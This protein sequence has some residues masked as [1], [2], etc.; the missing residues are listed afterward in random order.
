M[1]KFMFLFEEYKNDNQFQR[2][3]PLIDLL[4]FDILITN[5]V[6][7][8]YYPNLQLIIFL[9]VVITDIIIVIGLNPFKK[10]MKFYITIFNN[11]MIL[12]LVVIIYYLSIIDENNLDRK[13]EIGTYIFQICIIQQLG[14]SFILFYIILFKVRMKLKSLKSQDEL[15][16][17]KEIIEL[18][19][20]RIEQ[21]IQE[22]TQTFKKVNDQCLQLSN[23]QNTKT[24]NAET[25]FQS[26]IQYLKKYNDSQN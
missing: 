20:F 11:C 18:I 24:K 15:D 26:R 22:C 13:Y 6:F 5:I 19:E 2:Y 21:F 7:L 17:D 14:N 9:F 8:F 1:E 25:N 4:K 12:S 10:T 23:E 16:Q 3:Y